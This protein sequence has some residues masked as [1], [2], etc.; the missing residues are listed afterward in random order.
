MAD[1]NAQKPESADKSLLVVDI[2]KKY[3][4]KHIRRLRKGRGRLMGKVQRLV[5]EL[6]DG[7]A[8]EG[9]VKPIVIVVRQKRKKGR[10]F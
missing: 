7:G 3:K 8:V 9:N 10:W 1:D 5:A 2:G 4:K 6:T